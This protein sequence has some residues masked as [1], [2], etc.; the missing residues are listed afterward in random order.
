M[1]LYLYDDD[2]T[3]TTAIVKTIIMTSVMMMT[4]VNSDGNYSNDYNVINHWPD[5]FW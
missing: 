5:R 1:T 3:T 2:N 4:S